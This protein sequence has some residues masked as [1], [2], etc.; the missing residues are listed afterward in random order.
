[1]GKLYRRFLFFGRFPFFGV[2][3]L[4]LFSATKHTVVFVFTIF[5]AKSKYVVL[6]FKWSDSSKMLANKKYFVFLKLAVSYIFN[7]ELSESLEHI[8][9]LLASESS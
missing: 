9:D 7:Y 6:F 8:V 2:V 3:N 5:K 4:K 1:M